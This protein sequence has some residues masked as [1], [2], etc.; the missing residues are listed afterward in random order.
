MT[1]EQKVEVFDE[2]L[3]MC[4]ECDSDSSMLLQALINCNIAMSSDFH[5]ELHGAYSCRE[6]LVI[7]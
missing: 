3:R 5:P 4:K 2:I 1:A 6:R 7:A